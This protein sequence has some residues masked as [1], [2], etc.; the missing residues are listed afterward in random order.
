MRTTAAPRREFSVKAVVS[1][2]RGRLAGDDNLRGIRVRGEITNPNVSARGNA[3]FDLKEG[4]SVLNCFAY[5]DDFLR[6]P[7]F[8]QGAAV[9]ATGN[10]STF[11]QRSSYQL[12]VR[13]IE[14]DGLGDVHRRSEERRV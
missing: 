10:I 5:E 9:I 14:L 2:I 4:D 11:E 13:Q 3:M 6:F 7:R 12:I 1:Y 8:A